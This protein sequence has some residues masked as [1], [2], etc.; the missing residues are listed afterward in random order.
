VAV[1]DGDGNVDGESTGVGVG[2]GVGS[3]VGGVGVRS[4]VGVSSTGGEP[5]SYE[6]G[7]PTMSP[8]GAAAQIGAA[9]SDATTYDAATITAS[10][11][12][13]SRDLLRF[14]CVSYAPTKRIRNK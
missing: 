11:I 3:G 2:S 10:E 8:Y 12:V 13:K 7:G 14:T 9:P 1:V 6:E 4:G 5:G